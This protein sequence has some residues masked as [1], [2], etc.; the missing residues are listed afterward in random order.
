MYD[1]FQDPEHIRWAKAV[2][3]RDKFTCRVCGA[4][5]IYLNSHHKNSWDMFEDQRFDVSNGVCLC[6]RCHSI[7]HEIY[8]AGQNTE[9]QFDEYCRMA[10]LINKIARRHLRE[11]K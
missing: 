2:K 8:G 7:F 11:N 1:R 5:N 3:A 10:S 4:K 6:D 9:C